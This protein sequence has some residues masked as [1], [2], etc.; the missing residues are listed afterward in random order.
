LLQTFL[1]GGDRDFL[2]KLEHA[3]PGLICLLRHFVL[4]CGFSLEPMDGPQCLIH[5]RR[6]ERPRSTDEAAPD[7]RNLDP[8]SSRLRLDTDPATDDEPSAVTAATAT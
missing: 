7:V 2:A 6:L 5:R 8:V 1:L 4:L 3:Q